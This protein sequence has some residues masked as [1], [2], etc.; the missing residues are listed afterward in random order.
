M[1]NH[2]CWD[3]CIRVARP[4]FTGRKRLFV[5][6][7]STNRTKAVKE[8]VD[9]KE[10]NHYLKLGGTLIKTLRGDTNANGEPSVKYVLAWRRLRRPSYPRPKKTP[11]DGSVA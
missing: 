10:V 3:E 11:A 8:L 9:E 6:H 1:V 5:P 4:K 7:N 2:A